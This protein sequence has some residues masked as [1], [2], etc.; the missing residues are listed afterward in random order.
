MSLNSIVMVPVGSSP[1]PRFSAEP[2]SWAGTW[3]PVP[4]N[5]RGPAPR[6]ATPGHPALAEGEAVGLSARVG[7][8][9]LAGALGDGTALADE[10]VHPLLRE[11][12][13]AAGVGVG[14]VR[15]AR[16]L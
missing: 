5:A 14:S 3:D 6:A 13:V 15:L 9:D 2:A 8:G 1:M 4:W 11:G 12:A 7:E 10:L 16:W